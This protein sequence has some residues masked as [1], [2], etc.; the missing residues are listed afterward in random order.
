MA[1]DEPAFLVVGYV[2]RPHGIRGELFVESL[3][4]HPGD[5]FVPGVVLRPGEDDQPD[6]A[7]EPL[8]IESTRPFQDGWLVAFEGVEDRNA[9]DVLRGRYLLIER[10]RLPELA[11]D[12]VFQHQL[13]GM[14]VFTA[15]GA[16]LGEVTELFDLRPANLL[17]VRTARGRVLVPWLEHMIK[18]VDVAGRR[19]VIDPPEGLLDQ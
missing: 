5:V 11:A 12:E 18:E 3:T 8:T 10:A 4:D 16:E 7:A 17:E 19:I 6:P 2:R 9:S 15:D 13:I 1:A 14:R